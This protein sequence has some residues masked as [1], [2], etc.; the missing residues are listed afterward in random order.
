MYLNDN[1]LER[2]NEKAQISFKLHG[3]SGEFNLHLVKY[4]RSLLSAVNSKESK[5]GYVFIHSLS[6]NLGVLGGCMGRSAFTLDHREVVY[7]KDEGVIEI[8]TNDISTMN[9]IAVESEEKAK[10]NYAAWLADRHEAVK[11]VNALPKEYEV[12]E[13]EGWRVYLERSDA[14]KFDPKLTHKIIGGDGPSFYI[15]VCTVRGGTRGKQLIFVSPYIT[16]D[17]KLRVKALERDLEW[18]IPGL[19]T[20]EK[21]VRELLKAVVRVQKELDADVVK[22]K[23]SQI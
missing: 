9:R 21:S 16:I 23:K 17:G 12:I 14:H 11:R 4:G 18:H 8:I 10:A 6:P 3:Y 7:L 15:V 5:L 19:K 1:V 13:Y 2:V 22:A 20:S